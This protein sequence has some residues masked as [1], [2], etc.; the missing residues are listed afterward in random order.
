MNFHGPGFGGHLKIARR[1][2]K[3][4][5]TRPSHSAEKNQRQ[6]GIEKISLQAL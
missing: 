1:R 5:P 6:Y 3:I 4:I 2:E